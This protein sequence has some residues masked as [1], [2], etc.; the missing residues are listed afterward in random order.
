MLYNI[1]F[2]LEM[3]GEYYLWKQELRPLNDQLFYD[4]RRGLQG[5]HTE[6][7]N[8]GKEEEELYHRIHI[9]LSVDSRR[10]QEDLLDEL[11]YRM[12]SRKGSPETDCIPTSPLRAESTPPTP[13]RS[14]L[15]SQ[16]SIER[17]PPL[18]PQDLAYRIKEVADS[19]EGSQ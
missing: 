18:N 4:L 5:L 10:A 1:P 12:G 6:P 19:E 7:L 14:D 9:A 13:S 2:E 15:A 17:S 16:V 11:E 8:Q 3:S